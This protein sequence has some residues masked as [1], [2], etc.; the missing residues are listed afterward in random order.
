M[1]KLGTSLLLMLTIATHAMDSTL[2]TNDTDFV[3]ELKS[4]RV[5]V[6]AHYNE[7]LASILKQT[8]T[9]ANANTPNTITFR[10]FDPAGNEIP[11]IYSPST[12]SIPT[13][14]G[15]R[16][17]LYDFAVWISEAALLDWNLDEKN[18]EIIFTIKSE[19]TQHRPPDGRGEA[20]RH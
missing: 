15:T 10:L 2:S 4:R 8:E 14:G 13:I 11:L 17:S 3:K 20:P 1:L 18:R 19:D 6:G 7:F 5:W 12:N 9:S 16:F